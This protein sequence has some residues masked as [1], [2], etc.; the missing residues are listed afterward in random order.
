MSFFTNDILNVVYFLFG[1]LFSNIAKIILFAVLFILAIEELRLTYSIYKDKTKHPILYV[2]P[3]IREFM[4]IRHDSE[5]RVL[6]FLKAIAGYFILLTIVLGVLFTIMP[7]HNMTAFAQ[8][9]YL[10]FGVLMMAVLAYGNINTMCEVA[11]LDAKY[12]SF[13]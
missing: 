2:I 12:D 10:L 13:N 9:G 8:C 3:I 11:D 1:N 4:I 5:H 7:T 6:N